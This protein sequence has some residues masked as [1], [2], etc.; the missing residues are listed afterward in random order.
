MKCLGYVVQSGYMGYLSDGR[1]SLFSTED[2]YREYMGDDED[3][4]ST[5]TDE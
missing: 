1:Y 4:K 3:E 5:D 2:D